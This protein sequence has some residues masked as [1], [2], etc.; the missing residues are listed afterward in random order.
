MDQ[1]GLNLDWLVALA[2]SPVSLGL[3]VF[4]LVA[5]I[6]R[7]F[8][9]RKPPI[10][11]NPWL[12]RG[13]AAV[14]G[15]ALS[16]TIYAVT[17]KATLG[18]PGWIGAALFSFFAAVVSVAGRD[19][20]KT[21]LGYFGGGVAIQ[22]AQQVNIQQP[23]PPAEIPLPD[24]LDTATIDPRATIIIERPTSGLEVIP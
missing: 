9:R 22:D 5:T 14:V 6:K 1:S 2:G 7:D 20:L 13:I 8:E 16:L 10:T 24:S 4:G 11:W 15:M 3:L 17:G 18:Q 19:G 21:V 12:W 23:G